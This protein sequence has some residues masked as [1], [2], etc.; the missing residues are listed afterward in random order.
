MVQHE[1]FRSGVIVESIEDVLDVPLSSMDAP[2][3]TLSGLLRELV[4]GSVEFSGRSVAVLDIGKVA[5][6]ITQ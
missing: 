4:S 6:R 5:A 1:M 3:P 2:L